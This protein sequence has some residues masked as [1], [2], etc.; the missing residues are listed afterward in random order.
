MKH[1]LL[2]ILLTFLFI[3]T[4]SIAQTGPDSKPLENVNPAKFKELLSKKDG[5]LIDLRTPSEIQQGCIKGSVMIDY[6]DKGFEKEFAR[7][8]KSKPTYIYC[9]GGG[10]SADA[11]QYL[12][13]HG[14]TKVINLEKGFKDWKKQG[15][16][17]ELMK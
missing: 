12:I 14:F 8:D 4:S 9:A 5:I 15:M 10:R 3:S 2:L 6:S 17:V 1:T 7:L 16:E 13:E 11:A